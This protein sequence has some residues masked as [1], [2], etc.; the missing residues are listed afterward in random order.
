MHRGN[1]LEIGVHLACLSGLS[2]LFHFIIV[3]IFM[4]GVRLSFMAFLF[5]LL[6]P[7]IIIGLFLWL[8]TNTVIARIDL[9]YQ[10]HG[11]I[12]EEYGLHTGLTTGLGEQSA[13]VLWWLVYTVLAIL[14]IT[15]NVLLWGWIG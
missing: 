6:G 14:F 12:N 7:T 8:W 15:M 9:L 3:D 5:A 1:A 13:R 2:L 4:V 10:K 11:P